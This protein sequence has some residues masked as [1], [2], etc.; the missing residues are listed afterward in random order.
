MARSPLHAGGHGWHRLLRREKSTDVILKAALEQVELAVEAAH[1]II[2]VVNVQE[3]VVALDR[4]AS[5]RLRCCGKPVLVAVNKV[6]SDRLQARRWSLRS[7]VSS[8]SFP[9]RQFT[10]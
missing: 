3:G 5:D 6:D 2:F 4:E 8:G 10:A 9:S 1:V 7:W